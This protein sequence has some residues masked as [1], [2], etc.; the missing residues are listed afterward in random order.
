MNPQQ[1]TDF[2]KENHDKKKIILV[3]EKHVFNYNSN[4]NNKESNNQIARQDYILDLL[5][6]KDTILYTEL[7][8]DIQHKAINRKFMENKMTAP[9]ILIKAKEHNI[10]II[11]SSISSKMRNFNKSCNDDY[12]KDILNSFKDKSCIVAFMGIFHIKPIYKILKSI[13]PEIKVL[14]LTSL[15][16]EVVKKSRKIKKSIRLS[17]L[18]ESIKNSLRK[19]KNNPD[20]KPNLSNHKSFM[21]NNSNNEI[22]NNRYIFE[23]NKKFKNNLQNRRSKIMS[24]HRIPT[25]KESLNRKMAELF[26]S[27]K[28]NIENKKVGSY[29]PIKLFNAQGDPI[30]KCP[31]CGFVSGTNIKF[32]Q[33][34]YDCSNKNKN[35]ILE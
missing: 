13:A 30:I 35:P 33:H 26:P 32:F 2:L 10:P 24:K 31:E 11:Y 20:F 9:F 28:L 15:S 14:Q 22:I 8:Y 29:I 19:L 7:P 18:E 12:A 23:H 6:E 16:M 17:K 3:G 1:I 4:I 34:K 21:L 5:D 27:S 25:K